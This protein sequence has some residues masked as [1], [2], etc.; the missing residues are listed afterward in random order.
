MVKEAVLKGECPFP[1]EECRQRKE[2]IIGNMGKRPLSTPQFIAMGFWLSRADTPETD[3]ML[4][5]ISMSRRN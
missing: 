1:P 3:E 2:G 5:L 4:R